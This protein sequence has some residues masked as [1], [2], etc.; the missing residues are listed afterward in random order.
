MSHK[1]SY[2]VSIKHVVCLAL[3]LGAAG[4]SAARPAQAL[5]TWI[6]SWDYVLRHD[7]EGNPQAAFA[8]LRGD[9]EALLWLT[10][11]RYPAGEDKPETL[12]MTATVSQK[13]YLGRSPPRGR[14]TVYWFDDRSPE[15]AYWTYRDKAGQMA[16]AEQVS[17]FLEK[18]TDARTLI[19]ELS[20]Y[21]YET[22]RSEFQFDAA[23]TKAVADRFRQDCRDIAGR[24]SADLALAR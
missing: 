1:P 13:S 5:A 15:L 22:Q 19:I 8:R 21:R 11:A 4:L 14:S 18:L 3:V 24:T 17:V 23:D 7:P 6:G 2:F 12:S 10:C 9:N 16:N 20:N